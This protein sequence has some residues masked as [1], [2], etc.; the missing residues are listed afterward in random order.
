V[1]DQHDKTCHVSTY[2]YLEV[3]RITVLW[4]TSPKVFDNFLLKS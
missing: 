1:E 4:P 3:L 2:L